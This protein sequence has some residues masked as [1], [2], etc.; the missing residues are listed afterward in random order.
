MSYRDKLLEKCGCTYNARYR[1]CHSFRNQTPC[2]KMRHIPTCGHA[3]CREC[4]GSRCAC[5]FEEGRY[6]CY[7]QRCR[8]WQHTSYCEYEK[9]RA[10]TSYTSNEDDEDD[11]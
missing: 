1:V 4:S 8:N 5:P 7:G 11:D 2:S 3:K 6:S 10:C 9:C